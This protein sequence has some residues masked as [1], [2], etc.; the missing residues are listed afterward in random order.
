MLGLVMDGKSPELLM[1]L[2]PS[3]MNYRLWQNAHMASMQVKSCR[4]G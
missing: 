4:P 3:L 1:A 2:M